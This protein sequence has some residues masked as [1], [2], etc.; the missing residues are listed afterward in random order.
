MWIITHGD[1]IENLTYDTL[2]GRIMRIDLA[3]GKFSAP[4]RAPSIG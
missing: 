1:N 3:N 4:W 2:A